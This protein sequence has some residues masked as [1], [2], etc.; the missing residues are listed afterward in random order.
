MQLILDIDEQLFN[1][2]A[3]VYRKDSEKSGELTFEQYFLQMIKKHC[4]DRLTIPRQGWA[5]AFKLMHENG[6]DEVIDVQ[7]HCQENVSEQ[8]HKGNGYKSL[9]E[10]FKD[11][12]GDYK[13]TEWDTGR[14][15]GKEEW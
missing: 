9:E 8:P 4:Q 10:L 12:N 7:I 11:Y 6:D 15:R 13:C 1:L 2:M 3:E 5:E 14:K